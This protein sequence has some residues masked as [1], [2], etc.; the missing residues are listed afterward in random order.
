MIFPTSKM[1]SGNLFNPDIRVKEEPRHELHDDDNYEIIDTTLAV[2]QNVKCE[3]FRYENSTQK[4]LQ[5]YD[6]NHENER[7]NIQIELECIDMKPN[8]LAVAKIEDYS[9]NQWPNSD[10]YKTGSKIKLETVG[11]LKKEILSEEATEL[12][13]GRGLNEKNEKECVEKSNCKKSLK[14]HVGIVQ[15][16]INNTCDICQKTFSKKPDLNRHIESVHNGISHTCNICPKTYSDKRSLKKHIDWVH[17]GVRH[18]CYICEKIFSRKDYL[19]THTESTFS[20]KSNLRRHTDSVH[21]RVRHACDICGK[22]F[23]QKVHLKIH[24]DIVHNRITQACDFCEKKFK[25]QTQLNRHVKS[26]HNDITYKCKICGKTFGQKRNL[27]AH[28]DVAH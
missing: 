26:S 16:G 12:N 25:Y 5:N 23:S 6:E 10:E 28:I 17:N 19:R 9:P 15:S 20:D 4:L 21:K 7:D 24:T 13:F 8:L 11:V 1:E 22:T 18:A 2:T 27:K 14:A 3:R